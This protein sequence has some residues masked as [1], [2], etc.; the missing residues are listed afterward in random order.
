LIREPPYKNLPALFLDLNQALLI[1]L[2]G[3]SV[4]EGSEQSD[5]AGGL[6]GEILPYR[7]Q[8]GPKQTYRKSSR[9]LKDGAVWCIS[10]QQSLKS[11]EIEVFREGG[12]GGERNINTQVPTHCSE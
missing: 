5:L 11:E 7:R 2:K 3:A 12:G 8:R 6:P 1:L 9:G 10:A 4:V